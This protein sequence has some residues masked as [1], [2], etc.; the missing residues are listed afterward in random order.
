M[1]RGIDPY[2]ISAIGIDFGQ[3]F[4]PMTHMCP[5]AAAAVFPTNV[6]NAIRDIRLRN[7]SCL[8]E[9]Q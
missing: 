4:G 2:C 8:P 7:C 6:G 3:E 5:Y 9:F 1:D